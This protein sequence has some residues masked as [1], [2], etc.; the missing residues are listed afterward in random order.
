MKSCSLFKNLPESFYKMTAYA[1]V[2][3]CLE[4]LIQS[5]SKKDNF[6]VVQITEYLAIIFERSLSSSHAK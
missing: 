6:S 5:I 1:M 4:I 3:S 2:G